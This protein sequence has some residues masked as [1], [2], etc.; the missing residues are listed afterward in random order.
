[1]ITILLLVIAV[2]EQ[3]NCV[4]GLESLFKVVNDN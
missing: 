4:L 1:M 3:N 2:N